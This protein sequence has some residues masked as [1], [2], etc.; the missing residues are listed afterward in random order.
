M[1]SFIVYNDLNTFHTLGRFLRSSDIPVMICWIS[2]W[3][4]GNS[5]KTKLNSRQ[6]EYLPI[7]QS[8]FYFSGLLMRKKHRLGLY[9]FISTYWMSLLFSV[10]SCWDIFM[11]VYICNKYLYIL[12]M[13]FVWLL[14]SLPL[15]VCLQ[16]KP[17]LGSLPGFL[18]RVQ[19]LFG[20][21]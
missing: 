17:F 19:L 11:V 18:I 3:Y 15:R 4:K 7:L 8:Q 10:I 6:N 2:I 12:T 1:F 21:L 9:L 13:I 5:R 20:C 16:S 14:N